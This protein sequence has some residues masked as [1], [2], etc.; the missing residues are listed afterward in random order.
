VKPI[1]HVADGR[2]VPLEKVRTAAKSLA[3]L[4]ALAATVAGTGRVDIA[5]HHL[6]AADRAGVLAERLRERLPQVRDLH[7]CQIGAAVGAHVGPGVL[8]AVISRV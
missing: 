6:D 4:E 7:V 1:L 5:V 8:G 3:R 2:I